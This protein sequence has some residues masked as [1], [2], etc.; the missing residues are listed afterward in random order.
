MDEPVAPSPEGQGVAL[1]V[2]TR[3]PS[4]QLSGRKT[5]LATAANSLEYLGYRV[6]IVVLASARPP[7]HWQHRQVH[8]VRLPGLAPA[9]V[10]A[11]AVV[12][13]KRGSF[14]ECL[15]DSPRVRREVARV[16]R[17][18]RAVVV[19]ADGLRTASPALASGRPVLVHLD[20]LLSDRYRALADE[21]DAG[22]A[23]VLGFFAGQIPRL[24]R[25]LARALAG[26]LLRIEAR[27][28]DVRERQVASQAA[29]VATTGEE[30]ARE[31]SR[32]TGR[33]VAVLP[34]AVDVLPAGDP[35]AAPAWSVVFLG[36]LDYAPN[37]AALR[38]WTDEV[39][40]VLDH[41]GGAD[42][43]LTVVGHDSSQA[44]APADQR[45]RY[46][47]YVEDLASELRR[48]RAMVV[49]I[50][51]GAGV[52]TKILDAFSVGLPVVSTSA[53][54][55]GLGAT[56]GRDL[57]VADDPRRFAEAVLRL[58]D[59]GAAAGRLGYAG[60][61]LLGACWSSQALH[62]RWQTC[63]APLPAQS[64]LKDFR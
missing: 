37:R 1:M 9:V 14:N 5:V 49:P 10:S 45:I 54:A 8:H 16:S 64:G 52:K 40:P 29:A 3:D 47:G 56:A 39:R 11:V 2:L 12:L 60:R 6:E 51:S 46:T 41:L 36:L 42:V 50:R 21:P 18:T 53:G 58:R 17:S 30:E 20:D 35:A 22:H 38:W 25:P 43:H 34:M 57:L 24:L 32:R 31:L 4:G 63:V 55:A 27:R 28:T 7:E 48:H 44:V 59:D 19:V 26:R 15:F 33:A 13:L 62:L 23:D 61:S